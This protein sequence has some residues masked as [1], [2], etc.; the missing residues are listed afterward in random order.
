MKNKITLLFAALMMTLGVCAQALTEEQKAEIAQRGAEKGY[1]PF[2]AEITGKEKLTSLDQIT[3]GM[4]IMIERDGLYITIYSLNTGGEGGY[5][6]VFMQEKPVGVGVWTT[7]AVSNKSN[8]YRLKTAHMT[9]INDVTKAKCYLGK[10]FYNNGEYKLN[11][12]NQEGSI[13]E[14]I[15]TVSS[16]GKWT[17]HYTSTNWNGTTNNNYLCVNSKDGELKISQSNAENEDCYFNVY[18]VTKRS[19]AQV[20]Y[21]ECNATLT[22][23]SGNTFSMVQKGWNDF[24]EFYA[25]TQ[26]TIKTGVYLP[27]NYGATLSNVYYHEASNEI[28]GRVKFPFTVSGTYAQIPVH[29]NLPNDVNKRFTVSEGEDNTIKIIDTQSADNWYGNQHNQWYILPQLDKNRN[30]TYSIKNVAK[31]KF[32]HVDASGAV[33][34]SDTPTYFKLNSG[35][36]TGCVR[37]ATTYYANNTIYLGNLHESNGGLKVSNTYGGSYSLRVTTISGEE[38]GG[39][40]AVGFVRRYTQGTS[41]WDGGQVDPNDAPDELKSEFE[42][43]THEGWETPGSTHLLYC[44]ETGITVTKL[45]NV[46]AKFEFTLEAGDQLVV[47]G[48]DIVNYIGEAVYADYHFGTAGLN[49]KDNTYTIENVFPGDY[50]IRYWVCHRTDNENGKNH[51][52]WNTSGKIT[53]T[54]AN[55]R[56]SI[57]DAPQNNTFV[58]NTTWYRMRLSDLLERYI[59]A[60]PDYMDWDNK[61]MLTNNDPSSDYAGLW[62]IVGDAENGYKFYNRAWGPGYA[63][64]TEGNEADAR[65]YLV[66]AA[67]AT[68]YDIVQ[69]ENAATNERYKFYVKVHGETDKYLNNRDGYLATWKNSAAL[70]NDGS[71][72]TFETVNTEG[73]DLDLV[74]VKNKV[75]QQW[76]PWLVEP[77]VVNAYTYIETAVNENNFASLMQK[78][79]SHYIALDGKAFKFENIDVANSG[80]TGKVLKITD[81]GN[82]VGGETTGTVK[83]YIQ[84]FYNQNGTFKLFSPAT[85]NYFGTPGTTSTT[86]AAGYVIK[87]LEGRAVG[88][89]NGS[90]YIHL[91]GDLNIMGYDSD[92]DEASYWN[93]SFNADIL[94][95]VDALAE[96]KRVY[97]KATTQDYKDNIRV[98]GYATQPTIDA[99]GTAISEAISS[100]EIQ[101]ATADVTTKKNTVVS[102]ELEAFFPTDCYFTITNKNGRGSVVYDPAKEKKDGNADYLWHGTATKN[103]NNLN[104]LW[105]FYY[106]PAKDAYYLYNVGKKQFANPNGTGGYGATWIFSDTPVAIS[107]TALDNPYF[108]IEG[109]GKTMAIST[110]YE[111]SIIVYNDVNDDGVP[112]KFEKSTV[113]FDPDLLSEL[114]EKVKAAGLIYVTSLNELDNAVIYG[115][116]TV[117]GPLEYVSGNEAVSTRFNNTGYIEANPENNVNEQF[118]ILRTENTPEG[119]YYLYN[120]TKQCF[121]DNDN[122]FTTTPVSSTH[123]KDITAW[124]ATPPYQ[125][126]VWVNDVKMNINYQGVVMDSYINMD[127]GNKFLIQYVKTDAE[128]TATALEAIKAQEFLNN[129][130]TTLG[131]PVDAKRTEFQTAINTHNAD[132]IATAKTAFVETEEVVM[133]D[134]GK[135]YKISTWWRGR[136]LPLTF[137]T[138]NSDNFQG[139]LPA[140]APVDGGE[141]AVFV[142]RKLDN[143]T[144]AF[145]TD[146]GYYLGWQADGDDKINA[147]GKT[148][149]HA[150]NWKVE[151]SNLDDMT[152]KLSWDEVFGK[153]N[154]VA[155]L[156][157]NSWYDYMFSYETKKF[158]NGQPGQKYYSDDAHTVYY[159]FEEVPYTLNQVNLGTISEDDKLLSGVEVGQTIGTFSAPYATVLPEGVTAY[160]GREYEADGVLSLT[161]SKTN[162]IPAKEGVFLV[163]NQG[164]NSIM[165]VPV[166]GEEIVPIESNALANTA[167]GPV[168]MQEGDYILARGNE[169][170]GIYVAKPVTEDPT[171]IVKQG[172]AFIRLGSEA[173]VKS[174]VLRFGGMPTNIEAIPSVSL[175]SQTIYD[176]SG[177]R[178]NEVT[179]SGLYI[180]NGKKVFIK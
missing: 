131:Y 31:Q 70:G 168:E 40:D 171:S 90:E 141:A 176:L 158:H 30:F 101:A 74:A 108:H 163:G 45:D 154:L 13:G 20:K 50:T 36:T 161:E 134:N 15:F 14:Y 84:L 138:E 123:L 89:K 64:K 125:W 10:P 54:G 39:E 121:V 127:E 1:Y 130:P 112:F 155:D 151:K 99:L 166:A 152:G 102:E 115:I 66:N 144:Y 56:L 105:G 9:L 5:H 12:S 143:G 92:I 167:T 156:N 126:E 37:F 35:A 69:N 128:A 109:E 19:T 58:A 77:E 53:V 63:L 136:T 7:E 98:P 82:A 78:R 179:K 75:K 44:A 137:V 26:D 96:A 122:A 29:L 153:F 170:I 21:V 38:L 24:Y 132:E 51:N 94:A 16:N 28:T 72:M 52:L 162:I 95:L 114:G 32:I 81:E 160:Y 4:E 67:D 174:L 22:G 71:V 47:L 43:S 91:G 173:G 60:Q 117:R 110:G 46:T 34:L 129:T 106:N 87:V 164:M 169:G 139:K 65:T 88:F 142:C 79:N 116:S 8:T 107:L 149:I 118:A 33:S 11:S 180:V 2:A 57:S 147:T 145:V 177:R 49:P 25:S 97:A 165:V 124:G 61:L 111:G 76:Q 157:N 178:V 150:N 68:S 120:I 100:T 27:N 62:C 23:P 59:S 113:P 42:K 133:P 146:N 140:Y 83:D 6:Q 86:D 135:A 148:Y 159:I 17:L 41:F 73:W 18:K 119:K 85:D 103:D 93:V 80:R 175:Q 55:Y 172:K 104:D 48:V 3:D